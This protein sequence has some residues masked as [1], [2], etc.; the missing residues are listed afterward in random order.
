MSLIVKL[1]Q[2]EGRRKGEEEQ[3]RVEED[4]PGYTQPPDVCRQSENTQFTYRTRHI[5]SPNVA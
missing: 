2:T 5:M 4:E 1:D 3:H